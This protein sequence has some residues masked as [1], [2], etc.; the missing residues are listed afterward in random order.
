M[1]WDLHITTKPIARKCYPCDAWKHICRVGLD[2]SDYDLCDWDTIIQAQSDG[3]KIKS[4]TQYIKTKGKW[5]GK[6][7][8]FRARIDLNEICL[9][10][11]L[12]PDD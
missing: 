11:N 8:V 1:S 7:S 10:Y 2:E 3:A 6:F 4:G 9:K 5:E 12:Y